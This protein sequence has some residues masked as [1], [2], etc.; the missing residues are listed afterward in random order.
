ML[1]S[2]AAE[3]LIP[4]AQLQPFVRSVKPYFSR[5]AILSF[6]EKC[7]THPGIVVGQLQKRGDIPYSHHRNLLTRVRHLLME[8]EN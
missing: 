8:S 4:Q 7:K 5:S 1:T 6:A 2:G 3:W